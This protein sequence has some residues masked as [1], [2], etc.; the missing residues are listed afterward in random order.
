MDKLRFLVETDFDQIPVLKQ[1]FID[2]NIWETKLS[3]DRK[4]IEDHKEKNK[5]EA[6]AN[7]PSLIDPQKT[8][9][10]KKFFEKREQHRIT[11]S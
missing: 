7:N 4:L 1:A 2:S 9:F 3:V 8:M 5:N 11:I 10:V 6:E